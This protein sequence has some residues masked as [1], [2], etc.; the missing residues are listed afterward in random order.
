MDGVICEG[1]EAGGHKGFTE[2]TTF[3][4]IRMV[5]EAVKIPIVAGGG[6]LCDVHGVLAALALGADGVY[7]G[8]RFMV[9]VESDSHPRVKE[10]VVNADDAC[11]VSLSKDRMIVR[12]LR[13]QF[14]EKYIETKH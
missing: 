1:F 2:V 7:V 13:N 5:A 9:T 10:A 6:G 4:L 3:V 14:T 8:T 11:T 12:D